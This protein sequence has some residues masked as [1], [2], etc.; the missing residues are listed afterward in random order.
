MWMSKA[1]NSWV[2]NSAESTLLLRYEIVSG[3][4]L[5]IVVTPVPVCAIEVDLMPAL[6]LPHSVSVKMVGDI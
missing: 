3:L 2:E 6:K 1:C 4:F 5:F